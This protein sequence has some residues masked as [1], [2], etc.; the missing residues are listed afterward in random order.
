MYFL[1]LFVV[2]VW[3][4]DRGE[5]VGKGETSLATRGNFILK[6]HTKNSR[7]NASFAMTFLAPVIC[8][9]E[10]ESTTG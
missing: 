4:V 8:S 2:C 10:K 3:M 1:S 7:S 5:R 9:I 6:N